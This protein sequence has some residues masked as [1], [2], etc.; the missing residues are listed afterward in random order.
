MSQ[1]FLAVH[2]LLQDTSMPVWS[3]S[4]NVSVVTMTM[5][6]MGKWLIINVMRHALEI[7]TKPVEVHGDYLF[8]IQ[9]RR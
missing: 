1:G 8:I 3:I 2:L 4:M 9:V 6:Y 7:Q 5:T